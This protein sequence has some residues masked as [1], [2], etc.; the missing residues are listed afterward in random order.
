MRRLPQFDDRFDALW[1]SVSASP[2]RLRALRTRAALEWRFRTELRGGRAII[3]VAEQ[4]EALSGYAVLVAR[5]DSDLGMALYDVADL[6]AAG[7]DPATLRNLLLGSIKIAREEG[8]DAMKFTTGT[9]AKRAP[10]DALKPYTY[11]LSFWQQYFKAP[12]SLSKDLSTADS[13]DF[14]WFDGF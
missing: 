5:K 2:V 13:W 3:L 10:A 8:A 9:P 7:D 11:R 1:N 4:G 12:A 14:S 6:Q